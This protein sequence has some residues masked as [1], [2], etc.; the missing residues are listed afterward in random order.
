[1]PG[2]GRQLPGG[3][4]KS[5]VTVSGGEKAGNEKIVAEILELTLAKL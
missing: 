4:A 2:G 5:P 1:M 3:T